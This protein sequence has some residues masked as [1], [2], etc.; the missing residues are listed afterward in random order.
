MT[1]ITGTGELS[2]EKT[3]GHRR[4]AQSGIGHKFADFNVKLSKKLNDKN[5]LIKNWNWPCGPD[6]EQ[7]Y[8]ILKLL[9]ALLSL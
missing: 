5:Y 2:R 9:F 6:F 8:S 7:W 3:T 1:S 4:P